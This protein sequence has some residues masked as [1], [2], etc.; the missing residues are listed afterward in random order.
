MIAELRKKVRSVYRKGTIPMK[1]VLIFIGVLLPFYVL[2]VI[3]GIS[4]ILNS[5]KF[6]AKGMS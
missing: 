2:L 6:S 4:Y 3:S 5:C 1:I